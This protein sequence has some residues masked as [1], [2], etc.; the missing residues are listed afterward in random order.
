MMRLINRGSG[1]KKEKGRLNLKTNEKNNNNKGLFRVS[2][3]VVRIH[4]GCR[5]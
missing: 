5:S 2:S 3:R 4:R 1:D